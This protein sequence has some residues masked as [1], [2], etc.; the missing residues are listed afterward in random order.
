MTLTSCLCLAEPLI[1][2][3]VTELI[4]VA[5]GYGDSVRVPGRDGAAVDT[6]RSSGGICRLFELI[7]GKPVH[8]FVC[9]LPSLE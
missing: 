4:N 7:Q 9:Q 6:S 5:S 3:Q 1:T 2:D 8:W